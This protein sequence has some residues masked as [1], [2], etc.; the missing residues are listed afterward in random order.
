MNERIIIIE[1]VRKLQLLGA[2]EKKLGNNGAAVTIEEKVRTMISKYSITAT[3]L[4]TS[5]PEPKTTSRPNS[6]PYS[7]PNPRYSEQKTYHSAE[8]A[9]R[10]AMEEILREHLNRMRE[11]E[12]KFKDDNRYWEGGTRERRDKF[13]EANGQSRNQY[14]S[15][16]K[17]YRYHVEFTVPDGYAI[18]RFIQRLSTQLNLS[19]E[20]YDE[21]EIKKGF[22]LTTIIGIKVYVTVVGQ[23]NHLATFKRTL[24]E[25]LEML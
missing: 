17:T 9:A 11:Q 10:S 18:K 6:N 5:D 7:N 23:Q 4:R 21:Y 25:A 2:S 3:E 19:I 12:S 16:E 15:T 24:H 13:W 8:D 1:K 22:F 20:E 14:K